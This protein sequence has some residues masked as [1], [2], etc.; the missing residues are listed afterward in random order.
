MIYNCSS[1]VPLPP[2]F[3]TGRKI[4]EEKIGNEKLE[5]QP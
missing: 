3:L 2:G 5:D 4:N 1:Q